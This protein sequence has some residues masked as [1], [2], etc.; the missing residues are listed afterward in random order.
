MVAGTERARG[1]VK[2]R[3]VWVRFRVVGVRVKVRVIGIRDN[4]EGQAQ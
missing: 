2:V 3:K 1:R 4:K